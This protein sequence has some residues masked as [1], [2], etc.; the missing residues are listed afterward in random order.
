[1]KIKEINRDRNSLLWEMT[2]LDLLWSWGHLMTMSQVT[3]EAWWV[4]H[5]Y[6]CYTMLLSHSS[7]GGSDSCKWLVEKFFKPYSLQVTAPQWVVQFYPCDLSQ[8]NKWPWSHEW[9]YPHPCTQD[10]GRAHHPIDSSWITHWA[11]G[12]RWE[13]GWQNMVPK[14]AKCLNVQETGTC[15]WSS[16]SVW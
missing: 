8:L 15:R 6:W 3:E 1:M 16:C 4:W 2:E 10:W 5:G 12:N 11:N 7:T 13:W 9:S 14:L